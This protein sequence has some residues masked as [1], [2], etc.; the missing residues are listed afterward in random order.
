MREKGLLLIIDDLITVYKT[1]ILY[2][3]LL[4]LNVPLPVL[5]PE[6]WGNGVH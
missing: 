5:G 4:S 2:D 1:F 6:I 3:M